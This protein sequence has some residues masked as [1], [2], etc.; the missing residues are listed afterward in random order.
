[1]LLRLIVD[2]VHDAANN[3]AKLF[4]IILN[5]VLPTRFLLRLE[6]KITNPKKLT[7]KLLHLVCLFYNLLNVCM[8]IAVM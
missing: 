5:N 3:Y 1:V 2:S 4:L 7:Q 6:I 8:F